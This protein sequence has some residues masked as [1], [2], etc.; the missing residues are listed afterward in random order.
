MPLVSVSP[1]AL[2]IALSTFIFLYLCRLTQQLT[3]ILEPE[4][5]SKFES[6]SSMNG[7]KHNTKNNTQR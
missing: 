6:L 5:T 4:F 1:S 3:A 7:N 2:T